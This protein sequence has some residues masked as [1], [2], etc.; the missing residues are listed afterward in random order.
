MARISDKLR[1]EAE[2]MFVED[3]LTCVQIA[4]RIP[5]SEQTLSK[6]RKAYRWD[7]KKDEWLTSPHQ[8]KSL[9]LKEYK[10][11]A[12]GKEPTINSDAISKISKAIDALDAKMNPRTVIMV[13]AE[14][15]EFLL[16]FFPELSEKNLEA[17]KQF[18]LHIIEKY[19]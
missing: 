12:E 4:E 1:A 6:Y 14:L 16:G 2:A 15:D 18:I 13:I 8:I 17:H 5:I 3:G 11:L 9:L 19:G 10:G 7:K